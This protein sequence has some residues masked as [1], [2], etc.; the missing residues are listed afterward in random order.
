MVRFWLS[1]GSLLDL[2]RKFRYKKASTCWKKPFFIGIQWR[3]EQGKPETALP[4][5]I[6]PISTNIKRVNPLIGRLKAH[7]WG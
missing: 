4:E 7:D 2:Q 5:L 3:L 6:N 1:I